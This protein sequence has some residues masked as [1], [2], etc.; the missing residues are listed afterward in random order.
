MEEEAVLELKYG[1]CFL[2]E[3]DV[4]FIYI[5]IYFDNLITNWKTKHYS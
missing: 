2:Y 1:Y 4:F 5:Y 3:V